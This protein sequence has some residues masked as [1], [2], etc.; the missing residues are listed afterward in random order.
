MGDL[1]VP[2]YRLPSYHANK[3]QSWTIRRPIP[4]EKHIVTDWVKKHFSEKWASECEVACSQ[5]P[6]SCLMAI[7]DGK[8]LGFACFNVTYLNFFGPTGVHPDARGKGIGRALLLTSLQEMKHMGYAY[9]IIG[10]AGPVSFYKKA[11]GAIEIPDSNDG[12]YHG[13]LQERET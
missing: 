4:P 13:M 2:L 7:E 10:G 9:A 3:Q 8:I 12:A 1:L 5:T 6:A 11:V